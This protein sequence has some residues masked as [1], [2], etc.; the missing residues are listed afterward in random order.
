MPFVISASYIHAYRAVQTKKRFT[1]K[2]TIFIE[3]V[4]KCMN[5]SDIVTK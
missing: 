5:A 2:K 3:N 4:R 1:E